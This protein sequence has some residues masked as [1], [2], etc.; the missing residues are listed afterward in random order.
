MIRAYGLTGGIGSGK[1][2]A[3]SMLADLGAAV[4]DADA[5]S[6]AVTQPDGVALPAI[7]AAFGA[8]VAPDGG[9]LDRA[10]LRERVFQ[11][12]AARARLEA[13]LHPLIGVEM[14]R[15]LAVARGPYALLV[16]PLLFETGRLVDRMRAVVVV[17][18]AEALQI[19]RAGAR[20]GLSP[21]AVRAVMA[22][23]WPRWRRL[24]AADEVLWNG[25]DRQA[26]AEQC[27]LLHGR[28]AGQ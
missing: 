20:S 12:P 24:Q 5:I 13:I 11:D 4:I 7:R 26:L 27:R 28:L 18:C 22:A 21:E 25:A 14:D 6:H 16:V 8:T 15:Q 10:A 3:A 2:T 17:D 9:G 1:S 23:Q 19:A